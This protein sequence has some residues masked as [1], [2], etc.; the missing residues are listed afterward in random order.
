MRHVETESGRVR[1][2]RL[3]EDAFEILFIAPICSADSE[4]QRPREPEFLEFN[5]LHA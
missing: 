4:V 2:I 5:P 1:W 3:A